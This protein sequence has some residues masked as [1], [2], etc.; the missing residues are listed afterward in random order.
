MEDILSCQILNW[1]KIYEFTHCTVRVRVQC[2]CNSIVRGI[3]LSLNQYCWFGSIRTRQ[4]LSDP[5]PT[6]TPH[7]KIENSLFFIFAQIVLKT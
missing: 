1:E 7:L 6:L 4:V 5:D 3:Q 2:T